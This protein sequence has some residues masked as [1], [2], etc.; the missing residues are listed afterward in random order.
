MAKLLLQ[1]QF[2]S[3]ENGLYIHGTDQG[4]F[5]VPAAS[6]CSIILASHIIFFS[7]PPPAIIVSLELCSSLAV[8]KKHEEMRPRQRWQV[9]WI[10]YGS[11]MCDNFTPEA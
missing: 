4:R 9:V 3:L 7:H 2:P 8:E 1:A 5:Q 10:F 11:K 6:R